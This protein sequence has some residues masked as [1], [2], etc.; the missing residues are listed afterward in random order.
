MKRNYPFPMADEQ[1]ADTSNIQTVQLQQLA[2]QKESLSLEQIKVCIS[3]HHLFLSTGGAGGDWTTILLK[4]RVLGIYT[5]G[6]GQSGAQ[7]SFEHLHLGSEQF[8]TPIELPFSNFCC[9]YAP[10]VDFSQSNL[11]YCLFTDAFLTNTSFV[12]AKLY[13][14]D[15]SRANLSNADFTNADCSG[16]DFENCN[17][18]SANFTNTN[19]RG[20][21]FPGANL[22]GV[23]Y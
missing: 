20:A 7:A 9:V 2:A 3:N 19:L 5:G 17:L 4:G 8:P 13:N 18:Q 1:G 11:T 15:F 12:D 23:I 16:V 21:R 22:Q 10:Y 6:D 14:S